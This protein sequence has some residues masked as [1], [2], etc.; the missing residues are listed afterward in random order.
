MWNNMYMLKISKIYRHVK[1]LEAVT[2][3][4]VRNGDFLNAIPSKK[5]WRD[6]FLLWFMVYI[7]FFFWKRKSQSRSENNLIEPLNKSD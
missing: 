5:K 3:E 7:Y 4:E 2:S 1:L 6:N